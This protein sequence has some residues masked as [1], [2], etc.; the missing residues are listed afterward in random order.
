M[1][2]TN[3]S[4]VVEVRLKFRLSSCWIAIGS[5]GWWVVIEE[6]TIAGVIYNIGIDLE[7]KRRRKKNM[8]LGKVDHL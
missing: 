7:W 5:V 2:K 3:D 8:N 4:I 1:R 6:G